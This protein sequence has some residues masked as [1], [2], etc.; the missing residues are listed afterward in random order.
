MFSVSDTDTVQNT[1]KIIIVIWE[2]N[3]L[4]VS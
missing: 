1:E 3:E 2:K 4:K